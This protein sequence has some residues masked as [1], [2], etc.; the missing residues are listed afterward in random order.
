MSNTDT[1]LEER[2][3]EAGFGNQAIIRDVKR[4]E[5][6]DF[7]QEELSKKDE[8]WREKIRG[9]LLAQ[10]DIYGIGVDMAVYSDAAINALL[11]KEGGDTL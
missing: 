3:R 5:L 9:C 1:T 4:Y 7:I 10:G 8:E 2:L 6:L 11:S